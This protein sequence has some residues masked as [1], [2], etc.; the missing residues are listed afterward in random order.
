[1]LGE[2]VLHDDVV[3]MRVDTDVAVAGEGELHHAA[4]DAVRAVF[5]AHTVNDV[6]GEGVVNPLTLENLLVGRLR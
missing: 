4:E 2:V 1:M 3:A 6:I 5:A